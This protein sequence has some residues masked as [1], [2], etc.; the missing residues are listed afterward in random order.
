MPKPPKPRAPKAPKPK[1]PF[2]FAQDGDFIKALEMML[3]PRHRS[4]STR[5]GPHQLTLLHIA[6]QKNDINAAKMLIES[7]T[8][9][10][11][12]GG[13]YKH[14]FT[15][16]IHALKYSNDDTVLA[17]LDLGANPRAETTCGQ[18]ALN[19]A[20]DI[21]RSEKVIQAITNRLE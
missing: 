9:V 4:L 20:L 2:D 11:V 12:L 19:Y 21:K 14:T 1:R 15:S 17:L 8:H 5:F 16:L 7:G 3:T 10:D 6:V 13:E 18:D